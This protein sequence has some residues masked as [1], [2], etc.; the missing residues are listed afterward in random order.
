[1]INFQNLGVHDLEQMIKECEEGEIKEAIREA[2][3]GYYEWEKNR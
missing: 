3:E 1:M 2:L